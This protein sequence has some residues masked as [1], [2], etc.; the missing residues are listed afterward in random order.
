MF[1]ISRRLD[2]GLQLMI[3][4]ASDPENRPQATAA[5][6]KDLSIPLPF[7]HQIGHTLM[8]AGLVKATPGPKGGLRL[9]QPIESITV[10]TIS[11]ALEG[12]LC[13]NQCINCDVTCPHDNQCAQKMLWNELQ[14]SIIEYLQSITLA[15]LVD[16]KR[17]GNSISLPF[18]MSTEKQP[19]H[20]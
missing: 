2:Y 9:N 7:L 4:L 19:S 14:E 8:Q 16:I 17:T 15:S 18:K 12:P 5:L 10:L 20:L 13:V 1:R 6:A 3:T 11:E